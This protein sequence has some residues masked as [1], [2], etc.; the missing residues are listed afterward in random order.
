MTLITW[1]A[2][3]PTAAP[4]SSAS[5]TETTPE[6]LYEEEH[7]KILSGSGRSGSPTRGWTGAGCATASTSSIRAFVHDRTTRPSSIP[8]S[9]R[10]ATTA[11]PTTFCTISSSLERR[12]PLRLDLAEAD[13]GY[14]H[15]PTS[16]TTS[17]VAGRHHRLS[18]ASI[19]LVL[20]AQAGMFPR[21]S[22]KNQSSFQDK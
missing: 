2:S 16:H 4:S 22:P 3:Y 20:A 9:W 14:R 18:D 11:S 13:A 10:L 15:A 8:P 7:D 21:L 19:P 12:D 17:G 5:D 1:S 6:N